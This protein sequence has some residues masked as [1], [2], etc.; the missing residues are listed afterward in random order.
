VHSQSDLVLRG[1]V[2]SYVL[3][4]RMKPNDLVCGHPVLR[5]SRPPAVVTGAALCEIL[6]RFRT[7]L[8]LAVPRLQD[9]LQGVFYCTDFSMD[10]RTGQAR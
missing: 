1:H 5:I 4:R 2:E 8:V 6:L 3:V 10:A 7:P 9:R